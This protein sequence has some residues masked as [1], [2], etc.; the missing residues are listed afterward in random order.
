[1]N[2]KSNPKSKAEDSRQPMLLENLIKPC[3]ASASMYIIVLTISY[4]PSHMLVYS[5]P[6]QCV[7][8]WLLVYVVL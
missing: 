2:P 6:F 7:V 4:D 8:A 1:M 5:S 3:K